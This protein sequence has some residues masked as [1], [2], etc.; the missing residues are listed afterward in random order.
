ME[1]EIKELKKGAGHKLL[2]SRAPKHLWD[3]CIELE[4]YIRSNTAHEIYKLDGEVV[5]TVMSGETSD[6]SKFCKLEWFEWVMFRDE[7]APFPDDVL[8][9]VYYL[10]PSIYVGPAMT[11][12]I[13][14]E[15]GQVLHRSTYQ[16]LAPGKMLDRDRSDAQEQFMARVY[17]WLGSCVLPRGLEDLGLEDTPQYD[18]YEYGAQNEQTFSQ[19]TEEL[20]HMQ[21][22]VTII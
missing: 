12:K 16:P 22:W 2:W 5:E 7:T 19:L 9:L 17:E 20:E 4:A 10:G 21:G 15:H 3:D 8:I 1:R 6:I 13:S 18:P 14:T 11:A